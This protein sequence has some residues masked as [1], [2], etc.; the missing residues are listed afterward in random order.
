VTAPGYVLRP[1]RP[2]DLGWVVQSHGELYARDYG[3][4]QRFEGLVARIVAD[5]VDGYD[6]AR[7]RCWIAE[8]NGE[9]VGSV[10]VTRDAT[11]PGVAKLRLLLV[12]PSARGLGLGRRLVDECTRFAREA[13]YH[14]IS[15]WTNSVLTAARQI[16]A[17]AGY[18]KVREEVHDSFGMP[19]IA[20]TWELVL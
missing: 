13:G 6:P 14:T 1:P 9:N 17:D 3:W 16:Y 2:G 5:F 11:R 10:F 4:D 19:L 18:E 8:R 7:E 12:H 15:L 20:E